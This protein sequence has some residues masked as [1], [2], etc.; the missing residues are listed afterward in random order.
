MSDRG[1]GHL[2]SGFRRE[3]HF[4]A[5]KGLKPVGGGGSIEGAVFNK[6]EIERLELRSHVLVGYPCRMERE[7]V[8]KVVPHQEGLPH[9][10]PTIDGDKLWLLVSLFGWTSA[11]PWKVTLC[12]LPLST[13]SALY[14]G[15]LV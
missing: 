6:T 12:T 4:Q 11:I 1:S 14:T 7:S 8:P 13:S 5:R 2:S 3:E 9:A 10:T 15:D